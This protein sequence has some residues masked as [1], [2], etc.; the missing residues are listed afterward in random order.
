MLKL[1]LMWLLLLLLLQLTM[2]MKMKIV[3]V[4]TTTMIKFWDEFR[5]VLRRACD[6]TR[7]RLVSSCLITSACGRV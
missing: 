5:P 6:V 2:T 7:H 3:V 4:V 1:M